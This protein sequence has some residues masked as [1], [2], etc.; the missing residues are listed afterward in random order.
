[1][2]TANNYG[3][4]GVNAALRDPV[5]SLVVWIAMCTAYCNSVTMPA[6]AASATVGPLLPI[7]PEY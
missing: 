1:M 3:W 2:P 7:T 5:V 4:S 6:S